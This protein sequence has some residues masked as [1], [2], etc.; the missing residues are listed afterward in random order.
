M[1]LLCLLETKVQKEKSD[2]IKEY[3]VLGW[4]FINN[5]HLGK[6]WICWNEKVVE[7]NVL[8]SSAQ[9]VSCNISMRQ[10][11]YRWVNSFVYGS[12]KGVGRRELWQNLGVVNN[13]IGQAPW[14]LAGDFNAVGNVSV[15]GDGMK[16]NYYKEE[17]GECLNRIEVF[18]LPFSGCFFTWN[19]RRG[20]EAFV[21]RKLDRVL[22]N[23]KWLDMVDSTEIEFQVGVLS[24]HSLVVISLGKLKSFGPKP[25]KYFGFWSEHEEFLNWVEEGWKIIVEGGSYVQIIC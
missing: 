11:D 4:G 20:D 2:S 23:E 14:L 9:A 6:I 24:N 21:A 7:I 17:F 15:K 16:L 1:D 8:N 22:G 12:N 18:D 10:G 3:I 13:Q 5:H 25:F 19:N